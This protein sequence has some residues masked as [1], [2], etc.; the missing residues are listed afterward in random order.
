M[1]Q[2]ITSGAQSANQSSGLN[3]DMEGRYDPEAKKWELSWNGY[4]LPRGVRINDIPP[5]ITMG[6]QVES[7]EKVD[8]TFEERNKKSKDKKKS[9]Y[10]AKKERLAKQLR[11][12]NT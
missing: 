2:D 10:F 12:E 5:R 3:R 7:W 1:N 6:K 9:D 11:G 4:P 8:E